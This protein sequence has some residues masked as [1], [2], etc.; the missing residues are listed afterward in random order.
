MK[1]MHKGLCGKVAITIRLV[2]NWSK[3]H[4][5]IFRDLI[6]YVTFLQTSEI[7][8]LCYDLSNGKVTF[9]HVIHVMCHISCVI[10]QVSD[11][12]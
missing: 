3:D 7:A 12:R 6:T 2:R 8:V 11:D 10:C 1:K 4:L 9:K 5:F